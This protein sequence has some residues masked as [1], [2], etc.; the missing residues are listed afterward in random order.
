[1]RTNVG[2][3][4]LTTSIKEQWT[5]ISLSFS[6]ETHRTQLMRQ[7]QMGLGVGSIKV[8]N[9][10][11]GIILHPELMTCNHVQYLERLVSQQRINRIVIS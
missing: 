5:A 8:I 6:M 10:T 7:S 11:P 1:M 3:V 2:L 9:N 4:N